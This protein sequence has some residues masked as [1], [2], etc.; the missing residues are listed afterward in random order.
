MATGAGLPPQPWPPQ[1][2]DNIQG[3]DPKQ[4]QRIHAEL[5]VAEAKAVVDEKAGGG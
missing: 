2:F 5:M 4:E 1:P 3:H